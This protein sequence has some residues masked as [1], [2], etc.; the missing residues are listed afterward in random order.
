MDAGLDS[1]TFSA[2][3]PVVA[4]ETV[5]PWKASLNGAFKTFTMTIK[6]AA[7]LAVAFNPVIAA[8]GSP[9]TGKVTLTGQAP[10]GGATVTLV[11]AAPGIVM[12]PESVVVPAGATNVSFPVTTVPLATDQNVSITATTR[13]VSKIGTVR[14]LAPVV[15][16][17]VLSSSTLQGG[18][19][20]SGRVNISGMAPAGGV[21]VTLTSSDVSV[22]P[23]VTIIVPAGTKTVGFSIP[24][25][26]VT[27]STEVTLTATTGVTSKTVVVTVTP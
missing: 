20:L 11:S 6:P 19:T 16:A 17:F 18:K 7:I 8:G 5:V 13:A 23:P 15:T 25:S 14:L 21:V 2:T 12:V 10:D 3:L 24:T 27:I 9:M 1:A 26:I 4:V 22:S